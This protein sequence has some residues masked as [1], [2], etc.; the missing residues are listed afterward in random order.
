M[1]LRANLFSAVL[2]TLWIFCVVIPARAGAGIDT[3]FAVRLN[4]E[5]RW[6][7]ESGA[8]S[9]Q[10]SYAPGLVAAPEFHLAGAGG[11]SI[12]V[13]PF[14]RYDSADRRRT[15]ADLREAYVLLFGAIGDG[16]WELRLGMDQVFWGVT[17]S[18]HL[19]DIVNQID[20]VEHPDGKAKLGQPMVHCTWSGGWGI[21]ELLALPYH[22]KRTF[23]GRSG[24]LRLPLVIDERK[25]EYESGDEERNLDLAAR[26]SHS[27]ASLDLGLSAFHGTSR[28]PSL[29]LVRDPD[30]VPSLGQHYAQIRQYG[31]DAQLTA[32]SWLLKLEA[33]RRNGS[34]NLSGRDEDY[35]ASVL[36]AEYSFYSAFGTASDLS[37]LGEWNYDGRGRRATPS[38]SSN[39]LENDYFLAARLAFNDVHGSEII[40][41]FLGDAGRATRTLALELDRRISDGVSI[42]LESIHL[43]G[44]DEADLHHETR[45]DSFIDL[46]L[47]YSF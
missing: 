8:H 41:S 38:R 45:K 43:L 37:L 44:I 17:E 31:L 14:L 3:D 23:P 29:Q 33:I 6:F 16:E 25:V 39:T 20:L 2:G 26:Y 47:R 34:P 1:Q 5:T 27:M 28:E 46:V 12:T 7:P 32:G 35:V 10:G 22:R 4:L 36:G 24:R 40:A 30:G 18:Q 19:V 15:H 13:A 42:N 11:G 9:G 21:V